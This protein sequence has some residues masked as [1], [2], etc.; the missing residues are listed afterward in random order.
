MPLRIVTKRTPGF[1][2]ILQL[3]MNRLTLFEWHRKGSR[4]QKMGR[5]VHQGS[6]GRGWEKRQ[7]GAGR[8]SIHFPGERHGYVL[9]ILSPSRKFHGGLK[10]AMHP[11]RNVPEQTMQ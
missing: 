11:G 10:R 2:F 5:R 1:D 4:L 3:Q 8:I 9:T 6:H 7:R